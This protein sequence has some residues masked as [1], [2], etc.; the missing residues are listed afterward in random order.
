MQSINYGGD[1]VGS[2]GLMCSA[3]DALST[4]YLRYLGY[5][6]YNSGMA[7]AIITMYTMCAN[8]YIVRK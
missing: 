7:R 2:V 4:W 8:V 3:I 6:R 1:T 5:L